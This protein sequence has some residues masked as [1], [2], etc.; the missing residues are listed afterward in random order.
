MNRYAIVPMIAAA[1]ISLHAAPAEAQATRTWVS[2]VGDDVNPCSRTAPCKTFPGAIS[3]TATGGEINCLDPG[4]FG[5]VTITKSITIDCGGMFGG[6]LAGS[7]TGV[8]VN[9]S[10]PGTPIVVNLRNLWIDGAG[11]T[12]GLR[13]IRFINGAQLNVHN[14]HIFGFKTSPAVGIE[15]APQTGSSVLLVTDSSITDNGISPSTGGGI[16]IAPSP[17]GSAFVTI[18]NTKIQFNINGLAT[19]STSG[20]ITATV[21]DSVISSNRVGIVSA[22]ANTVNML[23]ERTTV[24]NTIGTGINSASAAST[25]RINNS[26][27]TGNTTG[28]AS[29]GGGVIRSFGNNVFEGNGT[30]GA[31]TQQ[32]NLN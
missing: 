24:N 17:G 12:P 22:G 29:S 7:T 18:Q 13:G 20:P 28:L 27:I 16:G 23:V 8:T 19:A 31:P 4:S 5:A 6:I 9:A 1:T 32:G 14:V 21:R 11:I 10:P 15:F 26:V 2:G 30:D 25:I 3:K